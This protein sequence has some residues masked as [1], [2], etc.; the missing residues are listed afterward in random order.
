MSARPVPP[1]TMRTTPIESGVVPSGPRAC[2]GAG[3]AEQ[4]G[5]GEDGEDVQHPSVLSRPRWPVPSRAGSAHAPPVG[6]CG[7]GPALRHQGAGAARLRAPRPRER[8]D[9][10]LRADGAV[11]PAHRAPPRCAELRHPAPLAGASPRPRHLRAQRHRHRRQGARSTRRRASRG[12]RS[13]TAWSSSSR[14]RTPRSASARR[15]TSRAPRHPSRRCRSSSRASSTPGTPTPAGAATCTSTCARGPR[16]ASSRAS[17]STRWSPR[18]TPIR[19]A[20]ATPATSRCGRARS[21]T[22]P[23]RRRG[24]RRG[25]P[26]ARAGTSSAPRCRGATSAPEFDIHGGGLDLRFPHHENELAQSTAAG[27]AFARYWVHNGLVTVGDQKMSKSLGN[28]LLADDVLARARPAG[29]ALRA[30]R[31]ALPLEPRH[32][33]VVVRRGGGRARPHPRLPAARVRDAAGR[34]RR[35]AHRRHRPDALRRGDGRR[36]RRAAGARGHPRDACATA[37]PRSTRAIARRA[38]ARSR[39]VAVMTGILGIDPL[40]PRVDVR[41]TPRP[42]HPLSTPSCRR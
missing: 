2:D 10:R 37:T 33:R 1:I 19:A 15:R 38:R 27:D 13:R 36:P 28:F 20:S 21:R 16:T 40:D 6:W 42:R 8:H 7:D 41:R 29:R 34:R 5:G 11:G 14:A 3:G 12:G 31:R 4:H 26:G 30:R 39:E 23:R 25:A 18:R 24:T 35:S 17:R 22:S 32:H 9:L